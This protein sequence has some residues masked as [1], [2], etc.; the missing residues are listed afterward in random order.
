MA[1]KSSQK[2][3]KNAPTLPRTASWTSQLALATSWITQVALVDYPS[4][5]EIPPRTP[6]E[7]PNIS[8]IAQDYKVDYPS[9]PEILPR[10]LHEGPNIAQDCPRTFQEGPGCARAVRCIS[11]SK[12]TWSTCRRLRLEWH[13]VLAWKMKIDVSFA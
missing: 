2:R 12:R 1:L 11:S 9:S 3:P 7:G 4:A 8:Q 6:P 5:S 13:R 10:T